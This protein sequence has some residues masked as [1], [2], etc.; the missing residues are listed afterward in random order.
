MIL[1]FMFFQVLNDGL[2]NYEI[3]PKLDGMLANLI[4][5][6]GEGQK[7]PILEL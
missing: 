5:M 6:G 7:R 2:G 1:Y 4:W 3:N